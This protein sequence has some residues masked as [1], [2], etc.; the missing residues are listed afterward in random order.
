MSDL[1]SE[2]RNQLIQTSNDYKGEIR[3]AVKAVGETLGK[4][5]INAL[6]ISGSLI[7]SYLLYRGMTGGSGSKKSGKKKSVDSD[8]SEIKEDVYTMV[9]RLADKVVEQSLVFLLSVAKEKLVAFLNESENNGDTE[10]PA[11]ET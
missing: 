7:L 8:T 6:I 3:E 1:K 5:G 10:P 4:T 9:D 2:I 11:D